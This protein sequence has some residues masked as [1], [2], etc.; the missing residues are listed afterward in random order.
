MTGPGRLSIAR[1]MPDAPRK[2]GQNATVA[3]TS[4]AIATAQE[5]VERRTARSAEA[6]TARDAAITRRPRIGPETT[7][8]GPAPRRASTRR[9]VGPAFGRAAGSAPTVLRS[10][11]GPRRERRRGP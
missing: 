9:G 2:A 4:A 6:A 1:E 11:G 10:A 5:I 8:P 7:P 3:P